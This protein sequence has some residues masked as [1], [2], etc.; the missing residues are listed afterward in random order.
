MCNTAELPDRAMIE[1]LRLYAYNPDFLDITDV[2][3][4]EYHRRDC[5]DAFIDG[6]AFLAQESDPIEAF[7]RVTQELHTRYP[8]SPCSTV[9]VDLVID[10]HIAFMR[11]ATWARHEIFDVTRRDMVK[12]GR[13]ERMA[14]A[15]F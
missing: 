14:Y 2:M 4:E 10:L 9:D 11:G 5:I 13:A 8:V 3:A 7:E 1:A 6:A 12:I 15:P